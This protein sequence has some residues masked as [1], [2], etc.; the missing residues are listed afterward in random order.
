[1]IPPEARRMATAVRQLL[2][3][4]EY[5]ELVRTAEYK[6]EFCNGEMFAMAGASP[7][8]NAIVFNVAGGLF[9]RL[10][11]RPWRGFGSDQRLKV[12]ETGLYTYPDLAI[13]CGEPQFEV[14]CS[15]SLLNP[16]L[17]IEVFSPT[18]ESYDR[19]TKFE[20]YRRLESLQEYVLIPQDRY[21]IERYRR[22]AGTE[23]WLFTAVTDPR[24]RIHLTSVGC[25]L[26]LDEVYDRVEITA[27]RDPLR[28]PGREG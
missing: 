28:P 17:I 18:T 3:P 5:L 26:A 27:A 10:R 22:Q 15:R 13:V 21:R 20:H 1:M 19:G 23:G 6:S 2:T 11:D 25:D 24:T 12:S 14:G 8:H 7:E 9:S 4:A 16:I